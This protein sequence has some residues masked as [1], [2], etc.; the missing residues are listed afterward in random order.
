MSAS[1][2]KPTAH[3]AGR[4]GGW[5]I[6][7]GVISIVLGIAALLF[8]WWATLGIE[9]AIGVFLVIVGA[10]E[11]VR[12]FSQQPLVGTGWS[13]FFGVLSVAAGVLLLI[14]PIQG[15]ITLTLLLAVFFLA[16]GITKAISAYYLKPAAGWGWMLGSGVISIILGLIVVI[17][18]P[19][20]A[21]WLLGILFGIDLLFFGAAQIAFGLGVRRLQS[22]DLE[23]V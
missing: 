20:S 8:P 16:G 5:L 11:L 7:I 4:G 22:V 2:R 18:F 13:V 12:I 17:A 21:Y 15:A 19:G 23:R 6:T 14:Y 10:L 9:L 1:D 3:E